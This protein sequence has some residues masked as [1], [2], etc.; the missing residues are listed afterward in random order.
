MAV[1]SS[2]F[3]HLLSVGL[4]ISSVVG[5]FVLDR[6]FRNTQDHKIRLAIAGASRT[7]GLFSPVAAVL[8]LI[9]GIGNIHEL[10]AGTDTKWYSEG[11]LVA[12][13]VLYAIMVLNGTVYGPSLTRG[14]LK[15]LSAIEEQSAPPGA[16]SLLRST[17][18]QITLFYF[19]QFLFL[20]LVI[21]V[22]VFGSGKHPGAF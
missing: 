22:S 2:F 17:N 7:M 8:L 6:K 12:K 20:L 15:L 3:V 5:G 13:I 16:E 18:N 11:W 10:F 9:T 14:R 1:S 21:Y 19:V 4:L